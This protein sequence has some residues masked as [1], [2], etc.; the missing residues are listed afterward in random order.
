LS[1]ES[2]SALLSGGDHGPSLLAGDAGSSRMFR[3][4]TG[5]AK[6]QMPPKDKPAPNAAEVAVI[7]NWIDAGAKGPDG[8]EPDRKTLHTPKIAPVG[9]VRDAITSVAI[10][11]HGTKLAVARFRRVELLSLPNR[12]KI[13]EWN[14]HPGKVNAI[15]FSGDGRTLV[16]AT[17]IGGLVGE[18]RLWNVETGELVRAIS[19]HRDILYA[20]VL[21]P[22]GKTLATA[23]YDREIKLWNAETGAELRT[24]AGHNQAIYDLAFSPDGKVIATAS[25][26]HT[27]KLWKAATGERLDT[28]GQGLKEQYAVLFHP[29]KGLVIGGGVDNRI[30]VWQFVS[31]DKPQI[32]PILYTRFAHEGAVVRLAL[33]RDGSLL[34]S[35]GEDRTLKLWETSTF[36]EVQVYPRQSD[37]PVALAFLPDGKSLAVGRLDG[38]LDLLPVNPSSSAAAGPV[39]KVGETQTEADRPLAQVNEAEPND[40]FN[41]ATPLTVPAVA[42]G[43]IHANRPG[44]SRDVDL[45]RFESAAG[46][47]WV[48]EVNAARSGS[49]LDSKI[50]VLDAQGQPVL[51]AQLQAVRDSYI[52]FRGIDSNTR[53]VRLHNW[54]EMDLN[55]YL[56]M[57]GEV[58]KLFLYPRGPDSGFQLFPNSG[59]RITYFDT[60][61]T[62][63]AVNETC[64]IVE[65]HPPGEKLIPAGLPV[66]PVYYMNDDDAQRK[67]GTDSRLLFTAPADG[68]YLVR[69]TD[70]RDF[71]GENFKYQLTVRP[72]KPDFNVTLNG[73]NPTVNAGSGKAFSIAVDRID[74]FDGEIRIDIANPPPG[75]SV[76]TPIIVQAGQ[77]AASGNINALAGAPAPTPESAKATVVTATATVNG[78][79]VTKPVNNLGEIKLAPR[80]KALVAL[81][82]PGAPAPQSPI[83]RWTVLK[84]SEAKAQA[85]ELKV[86]DDGSVLASGTNADRERYVVTCPTDLK[87]ITAIRL[88]VLGDDSLPD[89]APGRGEGNGN[90][91]LTELMV[92]VASAAADAPDDAKNPGVKLIHPFADYAQPGHPIANVL[93]GKADTGWAIADPKPDNKFPIKRNGNDP[94]H[95]ASFETE[96][97]IGGEGG[98]ILTF[99]LDQASNVPKHN[100]GRFRISVSTDVLP[101][102]FAPPTELTITPGETITASLHVAREGFGGRVQFEARNLPHGVIVDN[103]G[104]NGILITEEHVERTIYLTASKWIEDQDRPFFLEALVEG[105]QCTW[106]IILHVRRAA[107]GQANAPRAATGAAQ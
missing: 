98:S 56:Y 36:T 106:P 80:P 96:R 97:P 20:A 69:V 55:Q 4:L 82:P 30:R 81:T 79:E 62:T 58:C 50:E 49:P 105:N 90:F 48:I 88:E 23:G 83:R 67:L 17:G 41:E 60:N 73:A 13:R 75:F 45:Y 1:L 51:R 99:T 78:R 35:A 102:V 95:F 19:G 103:I 16:A 89:K 59:S 11:P 37:V 38:T 68:A 47:D 93:D 24:L 15:T 72:T 28:L 70:V 42:S 65:P 44:T 87:G 9:P 91:V 71:Q 101:L 32:N 46:R 100:L 27:F 2:Y 40:N 63:H 31:R 61:A 66:F 18:A 86:L 43:V 29:Q 94:S 64:Y 25:G 107:A 84:P 54:E 33:S 12:Q 22:D 26:D 34:A 77:F 7:R 74:G 85:A 57:G 53:D 8:A 104:L 14:D 3:M 21:S 52:T 92:G 5:K 39:A 6:P 76:S 10:S